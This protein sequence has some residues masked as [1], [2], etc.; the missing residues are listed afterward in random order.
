MIFD[1]QPFIPILSDET[2]REIVEALKIKLESIQDPVRKSRAI[3]GILK[4]E[5]VFGILSKNPLKATSEMHREY[6]RILEHDSKPEKG[7]RKI[8]DD[9]VILIN[10]VLEPLFKSEIDNLTLY[11]IGLMEYALER[12]PYNFDIQLQLVKLYDQLGLSPSFQ[13][14][15]TNL[16]L[17]GV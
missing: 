10:E 12:S 17:K 7:E 6:L 5:K 4:V 2:R 11:R 3:I 14:G 1:L 15:I 16:N 9:L 13:Q 8:A